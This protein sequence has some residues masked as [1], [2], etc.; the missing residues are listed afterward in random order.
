MNGRQRIEAAFSPAGA[1]ELPVVIC[2]ENVFIRDH[3]A[4]L[5]AC[6]WWYRQSPDLEQQTQWMRD[7]TARVPQDWLHL[8]PFCSAEERADWPVEERADGVYRI[9]PVTGTAEK[10]SPPQISG[11]EGDAEVASVR[12]AKLPATFDEVDAHLAAHFGPE[13]LE[14]RQGKEV[15]RS[16]KRALA[17]APV[18]M[19]R[20]LAERFTAERFIYRPVSAPFWST[21]E[22]WG[23]E[24]MM[25]LAGRR[26]ELMEHA[27]ERMLTWSVR[28]VAVYALQ[29]VRGVWIEDCLSSLLSPAAFERLNATFV[30]TLVERI[31]SN[32]MRSIYYFTGNPAGKLDLIL[33]T[34]ADALA[35]E[36]SKKG[37]RVDVAE[38]A[39]WLQGKRVLLGNLDSHGVL[40]RGSEAALREEIARQ[41]RAGRANRS[42][43]IMSLGSPVT[44]DTP[45]ERVRLYCELAHELGWK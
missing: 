6:P 32:R 11:W 43:F 10:M 8:F 25:E 35:F 22:V 18:E 3:W 20:L 4:Q 42:R 30:R 41:M 39:T 34:G 1:P 15:A 36:E 31:R 33:A 28:H 29:G 14:G 23:F 45:V 19:A 24:G 40:E 37:F 26:P 5:T 12:A 21:Y 16:E 2:Y 27:C 7:V 9:H 17:G 38:L 13:V 44:P